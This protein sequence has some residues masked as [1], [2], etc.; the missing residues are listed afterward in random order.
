MTDK[1]LFA[2][3]YRLDTE[4]VGG[5][6]I[7]RKAYDT[8]WGRFVAIKTPSDVVMRSPVMLKAFIEES[9]LLEKLHHPNIVGVSQFYV[10]GEVD[11][12]CHLVMEWLD[13]S[14]EEV[15][16]DTQ[17]PWETA[18]ATAGKIISGLEHI[19]RQGV[20]HGDLKPANIFCSADLSEVKVGDLGIASTV[21]VEMTQRATFK[22]AAPELFSGAAGH[23]TPQSDVYSLGM[24]LYELYLGKAKFEQSLPDIYAA[25]LP[26]GTNNRWLNWHLDSARK[27]TPLAEIDN[28]IPVYVS[29]AIGHMTEKDP[30][31]RFRDLADVQ[32]ALQLQPTSQPHVEPDPQ[33]D[34]ARSK[35][36]GK[37]KA[38]P[39][40][41]PTA[42]PKSRKL[43]WWTMA[44]AL[45]FSVSLIALTIVGQD[46]KKTRQPTGSQVPAAVLDQLRATAERAKTLRV[47]D[48]T[49]ALQEG[50]RSLDALVGPAAASGGEANPLLAAESIQAM[51]D[52]ALATGK[53]H[54]R[55]GTGAEQMAMVEALCRQ[56]RLDCTAA[57]F[58]DEAESDHV[59]DPFTLDQAEVTNAEFRE[60]AEQT[61][62]QSDAERNGY[63]RE[64]SGGGSRRVEGMNWRTLAASAGAGGEA[65]PVRAMSYRDAAAYCQWAG[66][67]LPT[68]AEWEYAARGPER[69]VF[70]WGNT[71]DPVGFE[72]P[73]AM[74]EAAEQPAAGY[75]G[76]SGLAGSVW[77]WVD[78]G[79][80]Q[81]RALRGASYRETELV[82]WRWAVRREQ[83]EQS[84]HSDDGIRCARSAQA[85]PKT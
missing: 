22:Y 23:P 28:N 8:M 55:T 63:A 60:F 66:K 29:E 37:A 2:Q 19:H 16:R 27:L 18:S 47:D 50:L 34:K 51:L 61:R 26:G 32:L 72:W 40:D 58:A 79:T 78:G 46:S 77:E 33:Q 84:A 64:F 1:G 11:D 42:K 81:V 45:V 9:R 14:L 20:A 44:G 80:A 59:L 7:V 49:P 52:E 43:L 69:I 41:V 75:F 4:I 15:I 6:S 5:H 35:T 17:L 68:P 83:E 67:R 30:A 21:A 25:G 13:Q 36:R 54:F 12:A 73:G 74:R 71:P 65:Y 3:R 10:Q 56:S 39:A 24:L 57:N 62:Y 76:V 53:R 85:W 70:A 38:P 82:A 31:L 48:A